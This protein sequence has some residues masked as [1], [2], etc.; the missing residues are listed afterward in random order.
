[1]PR[2]KIRPG[3]QEGGNP[4]SGAGPVAQMLESRLLLSARPSDY[5]QYTLQLISKA[6]SS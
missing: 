5:E 6:T 1:M 4:R 2:S 3:R